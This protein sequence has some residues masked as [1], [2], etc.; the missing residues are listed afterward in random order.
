[1]ASIWDLL[2]GRFVPPRRSPSGLDVEQGSAVLLPSFD[3]FSLLSRWTVSG[4]SSPA[5]LTSPGAFP[6]R[7]GINWSCSFCLASIFFFTRRSLAS[8]LERVA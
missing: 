1:L 2:P 8:V 6:D 7:E 4:C 3:R 5:V